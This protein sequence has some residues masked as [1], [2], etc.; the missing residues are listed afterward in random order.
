MLPDG[1]KNLGVARSVERPAPDAAAFIAVRT[2]IADKFEGGVPPTP[3]ELRES[4][5]GVLQEMPPP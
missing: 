2:P 5:V 4:E 1:V 3:F